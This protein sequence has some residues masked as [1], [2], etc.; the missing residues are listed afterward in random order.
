MSDTPPRAST[1]RLEIPCDLKQVR[2]AAMALRAFLHQNAPESVSLVDCEL[3]F[4][5]ACNNAIENA[6]GAARTKPVLLEA[7]LLKGELEIRV[8]DQTPGFAWP[9]KATLPS[10]DSES[11]RGVFLI[12]AAMDYSD[13]V[14]VKEGNLLIM[15]KRL[16]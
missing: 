4:V 14:Q 11:G 9:K 13:Y 12:Q 16:R 8:I 3:A 6:A 15:R 5:E 7:R 2:P 1:W 10:E